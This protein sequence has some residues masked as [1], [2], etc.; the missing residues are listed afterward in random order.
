MSSKY[1][2]I[3]ILAAVFGLQFLFEHIFPQR[4]E[5]NDGK[6]ERFNIGIG[7]LN[8][9]LTIAPAFAL[10]QW[11]HLIEVKKIGLLN[12][13]H[14]PF[15]G[16]ILISILL[17]DV[18]MYCWHRL[19]HKI[20]FLWQFHV[21]HHKDKKMNTTTALRFHIIEILLS[22]PGKAIVIFIFGIDYMP[23][24]VYELLFFISIVIHHSNIFITEKADNIYRKLFASPLMH[25]IHHSII[26]NET[27]SNY[28]GLFSFWDVLFDTRIKKTSHEI[29]FGVTEEN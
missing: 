26:K 28:G 29:V 15:Y 10:V 14:L 20:S 25:R 5:I 19:N 6:N 11:T 17:L 2:Q 16:I 9:A 13:F 4:K 24:L 23:L 21:F 7:L 18:W 22:Y 1:I 3:I 8:V 27:N 12:Q